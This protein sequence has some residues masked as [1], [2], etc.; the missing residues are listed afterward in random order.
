MSGGAGRPTS[1]GGRGRG[2][3]GGA[4]LVARRVPDADGAVLGARH[5]L[6]GG[7]QRHRVHERLRRLQHAEALAAELPQPHRAVVRPREEADARDER[8]VA[9]DVLVALV[10]LRHG[11][12][13]PVPQLDRAVG[14]RREHAPLGV[15]ERQ[16]RPH[17]LVV[18]LEREHARA[19]APH[20]RR[21]V[22]RRRVQ[23]VAARPRADA[24]DHVLVPLEH[25]RRR[26]RRQVPLDHVL[27]VRARRSPSAA[28][29]SACPRSASGRGAS[30]CTRTRS[31]PSTAPAPTRAP[32]SRPPS[33]PG[34]SRRAAAHILLVAREGRRE[35]EELALDVH[36]I[37]VGHAVA[38]CAGE[39]ER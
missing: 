7:Q 36:G 35:L 21:L 15:V 1:A 5:P 38:G 17:R 24:R 39:D 4:H 22:P 30:T 2:R 14:R 13:L 6:A 16:H 19:V 33:A 3:R 12:R 20:A 8:E 11:A 31:R 37:G 9:H 32:T 34:C 23:Q 18:A 27:V 10:R 26:V 29:P 25:A 28:S